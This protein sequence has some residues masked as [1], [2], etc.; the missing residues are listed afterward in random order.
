MLRALVTSLLLICLGLG[1]TATAAPKGGSGQVS[2]GGVGPLRFGLS[3]ESEVLAFAGRP[4][5]VLNDENP[6]NGHSNVNYGYFCRKRCRTYYAINR[7]DDILSNFSTSAKRFHTVAGSRVG[8]RR[9][10]AIRKENRPVLPPRCFPTHMARTNDHAELHIV[11]NA[12][13]VTYLSVRT[14]F[15]DGPFWGC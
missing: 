2:L 12:R 10:V 8:M 13:K 14:D 3:T 6:Y 11:L 5:R 4:D 15:G 7:E 1:G 9:R